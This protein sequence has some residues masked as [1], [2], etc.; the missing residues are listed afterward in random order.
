MAV[1]GAGAENKEFRLRHT[2]FYTVHILNVTYGALHCCGSERLLFGSG[3][4][5]KVRIR[6]RL[7]GSDSDLDP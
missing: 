1:A 3:S 7:K 5:L 6:I 4:D 2:G